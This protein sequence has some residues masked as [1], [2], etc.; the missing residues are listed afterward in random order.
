VLKIPAGIDTD[1]LFAA[2]G[3]QVIRVPIKKDEGVA[4]IEAVCQGVRRRTDVHGWGILRTNRNVKIGN[5]H[6]G[7]LRC[8]RMSPF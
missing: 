7:N 5:I 1:P 3:I 8:F 6:Q 2:A 4:D